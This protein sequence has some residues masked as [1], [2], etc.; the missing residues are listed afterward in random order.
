MELNSIQRASPQLSE[1]GWAKLAGRFPELEDE[2]AGMLIGGDYA[3]PGRSPD[4][5]DACVWAM[6][7]LMKR[8]APPRIAAL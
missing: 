8:G 4:R 2:L 6:S 3:G 5:A 1:G 7:A